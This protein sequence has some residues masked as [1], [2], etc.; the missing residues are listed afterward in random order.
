MYT[1]FSGVT[2]TGNL[3]AAAFFL[4]FWSQSREGLFLFFAGAFALFAVTPILIGLLNI[5]QTQQS[6]FFLFRL[7][8]F[9]LIIIGIA[10]TNV[11]KR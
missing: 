10:W 8:G 1:F 7:A 4:R 11:R 9:V 2:A 5:P 6:E 3:I